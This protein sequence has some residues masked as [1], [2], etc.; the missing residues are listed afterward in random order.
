MMGRKPMIGVTP[1]WD[2]K[3]DSLWMLPGYFDGVRSAGGLPVMLP[4]TADK[5]V[6]TQCADTF[7][8]FLFTGG[9]DVSPSVYKEKEL[10]M[11]GDICSDRDKM[12]AILFE[13]AVS[14]RG[15]PAFGICRGIQLF[16][17]VLGG[18]LYQDLPSQQG[19]NHAQKPPYDAPLHKV[20][21]LSDT[22]LFELI[23]ESQISVNSYHHQAVKFLAP[24]LTAMA[25]SGD[26][27]VEAVY[28]PERAFVWAVQWHPE[29]WPENAVSKKLF[30]RFLSACRKY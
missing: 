20:S 15:K 12:E 5:S 30:D 16:N 29:L 14:E 2:G 13:E 10:P 21:I 17:A 24:K 23:D 1:L 19:V 6:I 11:C 18:T 3:K 28:M 8:G 4:L 9:H 26:G 27:I 22:P 7:D 25:V